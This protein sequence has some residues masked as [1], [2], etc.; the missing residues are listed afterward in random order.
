MPV[1]SC[2]DR[3]AIA[4]ATVCTAALTALS[5]CGEL[6]TSATLD[7]LAAPTITPI[8]HVVVVFQENVPFD[9][10]FATY[11][12]ALNLPGESRFV[13][14]PDTPSVN[15]LTDAL[16]RANPNAASPRRLGRE[17]PNVC[18]SNHSYTAEQRA[19]NRGL[20]DRFVEETGDHEP[21]CDPTLGMDYFDGNTVT[22]LWNYAQHFAIN[23]NSFGTTFGPSHIGVLNLVSGQTHG[24]VATQPTD[25]IV[26]G[27]VIGNIEPTFDDC[28]L[29]AFSM[30]M[31]ARAGFRPGFGP[32]S[33]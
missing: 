8:R 2:L 32:V 33:A 10:Y 3:P 4:T 16:L 29:S 21:G 5:A 15:G 23:D 9:R 7:E 31:T 26:E 12:H 24:A 11:P 19:A 13:A 18:G 22:A 14:R 17:Q 1:A 20:L 6:A 28:P 30:E 27:T 25:R